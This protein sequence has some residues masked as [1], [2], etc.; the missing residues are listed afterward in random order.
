MELYLVRHAVAFERDPAHWP[1]DSRRPLTPEGK[2]RFRKAA[3]GLAKL[4]P[5]VDAVFSSPYTRAVET[6]RL[7]EKEA[8]WPSASLT[9]VLGSDRSSHDVLAFLQT[10]T[11]NPAIA[12]IGHEPNLSELGSLLLTGDAGHV[13]LEMRKGGVAALH[14]EEQ[15]QP[16][17]AM[18]RW[19]VQPRTLR[20]VG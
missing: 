14:F 6:A 2:K 12:V 7:L 19:L 13:Q 1:D 5:E 16:G 8:D 15:V 18:L 9:A 3:R 20:Q 11:G 17:A 4:V 10:L